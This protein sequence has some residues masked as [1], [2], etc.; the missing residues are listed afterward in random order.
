VL[1]ELQEPQAKMEITEPRDPLDLKEI[2]EHLESR[3]HPRFQ[4]LLVHPDIQ[5]KM[6]LLEPLVA[7]GHKALLDPKGQ[8]GLLAKTAMLGALALLDLKES[9]ENPA[10]TEHQEKMD[11]QAHQALRPVPLDLKDQLVNLVTMALL[12][13]TVPLVPLALRAKMD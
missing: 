1:Q 3:F 10:T 12:E 6:E 5:E 7:L 2:L 11:V 4:A 13:K 9:L 8:L